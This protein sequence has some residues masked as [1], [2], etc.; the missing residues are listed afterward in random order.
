M[1]DVNV[2]DRAYS[3]Q[4]IEITGI[5]DSTSDSVAAIFR[6]RLDKATRDFVAHQR[7]GELNVN[8]RHGSPPPHSVRKADIS[9]AEREKSKSVVPEYLSR[10]P[11]Y[12]REF[13]VVSTEVREQL[14]SA[15]QIIALQPLLFE[16]WGLNEIE[17]YPK[18]ALNFHGPPGTGKTLAA[19]AVAAATARKIICA[20]YAD[21]ESMY[22]GEGPKNVTALF[23]AAEA[24]NA[25]LF[26]DEADS[27]LS[28]RLTN[29]TQGSEQAINSMRSQLLICL[30]NFK[31]IVVFATNLVSNY[32]PAFDTRVRHIHFPAPDRET[33]VLLWKRHL[34]GRLPLG[35]IC[36]ESLA[37]GSEGMVGR[38]IKMAVI[39]AAVAAARAGRRQVSQ[40]DFIAAI[41]AT[42]QARENKGMHG[43]LSA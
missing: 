17:P 15:M 19:H 33:R 40:G 24:S 41:E 39:D 12:T 43:T 8:V 2:V 3:S 25:V 36:L 10:D 31:G 26:I 13:L 30:D 35:E 20:S 22:H 42:K 23:K 16:T 11:L 5:P 27:L 29:V 1:N 7:L 38:E 32:D 4:I 28:K 18:S 21:I 6:S 34:P 37:D 14:E 9:E